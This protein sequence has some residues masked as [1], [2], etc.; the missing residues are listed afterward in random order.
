MYKL[1]QGGT[2]LLE[3]YK[4]SS[5]RRLWSRVPQFNQNLTVLFIAT[6]NNKGKIPRSFSGN[7]KKKTPCVSWESELDAHKLVAR[8]KAL[9]FTQLFIY[10]LTYFK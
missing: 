10:Y 5:S 2:L 7:C 8:G 1:I 6:M 4:F 9:V 3:C